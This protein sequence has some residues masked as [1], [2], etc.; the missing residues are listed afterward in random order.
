MRL[1]WSPFLWSPTLPLGLSPW[2]YCRILSWYRP[3][4]IWS[5]SIRLTLSMCL[6]MMW[7]TTVRLMWTDFQ[8]RSM[9]FNSTPISPCR[10]QTTIS[11]ISHGTQ[12]S[13][14]RVFTLSRS[15]MITDIMLHRSLNPSSLPIKLRLKYRPPIPLFPLSLFSHPW[16]LE[17]SQEVS[18]SN[19]PSF[20][21]SL[22]S[23]ILGACYWWSS[24]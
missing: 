2:I 21:S 19:P 14:E 10:Q 8:S 9:A 11:F 22:H 16:T 17:P 5:I 6:C 18:F 3:S 20:R 23:L 15:N 1:W 12:L 4:N 13:M 24:W 7:V